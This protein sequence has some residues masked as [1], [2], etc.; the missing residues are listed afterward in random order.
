MRHYKTIARLVLVVGL[1]M[2]GALAGN[3]LYGDQVSHPSHICTWG[4]MCSWVHAKDGAQVGC[5]PGVW[6]DSLNTA[7]FWKCLPSENFCDEPGRYGATLCVGFCQGTQT[8][9]SF[10]LVHCL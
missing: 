8:E 6:C 4:P 7:E 5:P 2:T 1:V 10:I 3:Q 9:C